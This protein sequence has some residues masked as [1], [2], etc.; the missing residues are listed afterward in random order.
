MSDRQS[1]YANAVT[2]VECIAHD[3]K[4]TLEL[5]V[6][7]YKTAQKILEEESAARGSDG[8]HVYKVMWRGTRSSNARTVF[9][10][11]SREEAEKWVKDNDLFE[12]DS[13]GKYVSMYLISEE[14]MEGDKLYKYGEEN[15]WTWAE[16]QKPNIFSDRLRYLLVLSREN[17][18]VTGWPKWYDDDS[19][20]E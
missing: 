13:D 7:A 18:G 1:Q 10:S 4:S 11:N 3:L 15:F 17:D 9:I 6:D 8:A 14:P 5:L 19:D 16:C 12:R 2:N 20:Y